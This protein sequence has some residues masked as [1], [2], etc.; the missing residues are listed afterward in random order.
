[1]EPLL[2][3][4]KILLT[5]PSPKTQTAIIIQ[6]DFAFWINCSRFAVR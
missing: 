4:Y 1:M 5:I 6:K 3:D 2:R